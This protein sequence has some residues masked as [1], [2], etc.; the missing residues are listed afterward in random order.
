MVRV[1]DLIHDGA[2]ESVEG[3]GAEQEQY[4]PQYPLSPRH[5][6]LYNNNNSITEFRTNTPAMTGNISNNST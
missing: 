5:I 6:V 2:E 3:E 4:Y 1:P